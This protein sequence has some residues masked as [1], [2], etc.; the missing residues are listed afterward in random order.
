MRGV[1][2]RA[3]QDLPGPTRG[4]QDLPRSFRAC[5]ARSA[6]LRQRR[7]GGRVFARAGRVERTGGSD[8]RPG[9]RRARLRYFGGRLLAGDE[10]QSLQNAFLVGELLKLFDLFVVVSEDG[11]RGDG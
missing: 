8:A 1:I 4:Y 3:Y 6:F 11:G 10:L 2:T 9:R 5:G 7:Y